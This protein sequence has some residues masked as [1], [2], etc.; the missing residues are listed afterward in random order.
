MAAELDSHVAGYW[1]RCL[2]VGHGDGL[3]I[4]PPTEEAVEA[5]V[6]ATGL[7]ADEALG[8]FPP[9]NATITVGDLAVNAVLAG[10]RAD[11]A[12]VLVSV[13]RALVQPEFDLVGVAT[14]TK[15]S[16]PLL[17]IN[18]P[19]RREIEVNC[20]GDVFG[21]R[22]RANATIGRTVRL[23]IINVGRS[24]PNE[25]DRGTLGHPGRFS[26]CIGEDEEGSPWEPLHVERG[27]GPEDSAVT[28]FGGEG[29][30]LVNVH[31]NTA[32]AVL[33]G[34]ADTLASTGIYNDH[35]IVRRAPCVV[36]FAKEH[37]DLLAGAGWTKQ[38]IRE[39]IF[40]EAVLSPEALRR[41][42]S[43]ADGPVPVLERPED[44]LLIAAGGVAGRFAGVI[45]GWSWQSQ[46][47]TERVE[48][49]AS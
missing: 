17:I 10:C 32:E 25:L 2:E 26:Y 8:Q 20:G 49:P 4:V 3:P 31:Y 42:G 14:S 39:S 1:E 48:F 41:V 44:I 6:R 34:V 13:V 29:M 43:D 35:N 15:G 27:C 22:F 46:P 7:A 23:L 9:S 12:P 37:R 21:A 45:P 33:A 11:Y 47:V 40:E 36:V 18:G 16:A 38:A 30:R 5:M 28:V 24:R 19:V